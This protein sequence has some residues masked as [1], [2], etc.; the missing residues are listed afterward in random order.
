LPDK[1]KSQYGRIRLA[2]AYTHI[3]LLTDNYDLLNKAKE[4]ILKEINNKEYSEAG[5]G[6]L[7]HQLGECF[8]GTNE[9]SKAEDSFLKSLSVDKRGIT[10]IFLA[11]ALTANNKHN[12]SRILLSNI[13]IQKLSKANIFD[14]AISLCRL[15]LNTKDNE[16]INLALDKI[17]TIQTNDPMFI[18]YVKEL[19]IELYELKS[20]VKS[21][22][23]A[24]TALGK[25]NRY[26]QLK[27][28]LMGVGV[29]FNAI[30]EDF[31]SK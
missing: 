5:L 3:G 19:T 28:N 4:K 29:D 22:I 2:D 24:E 1:D 18:N 6:Q 31:I 10:E 20:S 14:L 27:P 30:I 23:K 26:V 13:D 11:R 21:V 25:F 16:D 15:A 12:E 7:H 17:K 8:L 9:L